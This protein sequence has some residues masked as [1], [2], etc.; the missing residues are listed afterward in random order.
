MDN[1]EAILNAID[2][3]SQLASQN[4][5]LREELHRRWGNHVN[6][7]SDVRSSEIQR[8]EK[9]LAINYTIDDIAVGIDYSF[10]KDEGVRIRL[11]ADWREMLRCRCGLRKHAPEFLEF[12]RYAHLQA[13][14]IVN[15]YCYSKYSDDETLSGTLNKY[16]SE[17]R[18]SKDPKHYCEVKKGGL[19]TYNN[20]LNLLRIELSLAWNV[21]FTLFKRIYPARNSQSHSSP[22]K[23][24]DEELKEWIQEKPYIEVEKALFVLVNLIKIS[25]N[26]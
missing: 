20:K 9:Y 6:N 7:V 5:W 10:V 2:R 15:Y 16:F 13:E 19:P 4:P 21:F 11:E 14:G 3:I 23:S 8:I 1:K 18:D 25:F 22:M 17:A 26:R 24:S 12:C